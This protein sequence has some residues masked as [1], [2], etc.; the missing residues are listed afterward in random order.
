MFTCL[1]FYI[2]TLQCKKW[3]YNVSFVKFAPGLARWNGDLCSV[4]TRGEFDS[5]KKISNE[6][7]VLSHKLGVGDIHKFFSKFSIL[8]IE[9]CPYS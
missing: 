7:V 1:H 6:G 2:S 9:S 4:R 5:H 3:N 8:I